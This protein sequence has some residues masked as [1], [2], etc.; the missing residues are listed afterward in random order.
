[1]P[2]AR[3]D[4]VS[5][6][7]VLV[8]P[9]L[10]A[11]ARTI[12]TEYDGGT[13]RLAAAPVNGNGGSSGHRPGVIGRASSDAAVQAALRRITETEFTSAIEPRR[14]AGRASIFLAGSLAVIA[15]T[16]AV[17]LV[18]LKSRSSQAETS[19]DLF[20]AQR[21]H[22]SVGRTSSRQ[23]ADPTERDVSA[24]GD[25]SKSSPSRPVSMPTS[26]FAS[27]AI[28]RPRRFA[29]SPAHGATAYHVEVFR[30]RERIFVTDSLR[31]RVTIPSS[32]DL[33]GVRHQLEPEDRLYVW[34]VI[35]GTQAR[36]TIIRAK[37]E[38]LT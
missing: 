10:A 35:S 1:M 12:L 24:G 13:T 2:A 19:T 32:W 5:P 8:D 22:A 30:G 25:S 15:V 7:L 36:E 21:P 28:S 20:V 6:E 37:V 11:R 29:W 33:G 3:G 23:V 14:P 34:P 26:A 17:F 27:P 31:S 9:H 4:V 38:D 16:G 18:E